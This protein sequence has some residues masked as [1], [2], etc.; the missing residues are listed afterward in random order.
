MFAYESHYNSLHRFLCGQCQKHLPSA[1]LLDLH[2]SETHD[3]F[4]AVQV[5][6]KPMVSALFFHPSR[7]CSML[8][9]ILNLCPQYACYLE[10]CQHMSQTPAERHDH[11]ITQHKFPH[12]FRFDGFNHKR[13]MINSIKQS[14]SRSENN[15][16]KPSTSSIVQ[17]SKFAA[18]QVHDEDI[19]L[20]DK[21]IL[22]TAQRKPITSFS[23][24]HG[25][26]KTFSGAKL[27][28]HH[29]SYAMALTKKSKQPNKTSTSSTLEC[30]KMV[31]DL[32]ESLP[33]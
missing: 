12:D 19:V 30:E 11:C 27:S 14:N 20:E 15:N 23:F 16:K 7:H 32:M 17:A 18:N 2:L 6:K 26:A 31:E 4:F 21:S 24:G 9:R 28:T 29:K 10:E 1:H 5:D 33:Q 13:A 3:S 8:K 22:L 25:K